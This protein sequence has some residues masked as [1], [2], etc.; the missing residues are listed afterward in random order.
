MQ[1]N[2]TLKTKLLNGVRLTRKPWVRAKKQKNEPKKP[3]EPS[4]DRSQD[5][6]ASSG[7]GADLKEMTSSVPAQQN[8]PSFMQNEPIYDINHLYEQI[9]KLNNPNYAGNHNLSW[10]KIKLQL[11]TRNLDEL[12]RK[13]SE[14]NVTLRQIGVDEERSFVD[15][16][17]LIGERLLQKDYQPFLVQYAKRGV[18]PTLRARIYKKILYTDVTQKET[19]YMATL[20]DNL[21]KWELALEDQIMTDL[22]VT[23]NDDKYF[24]FQEH[25]ESM[26]LTFFRDR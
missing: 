18:P 25:I 5:D 1:W 12:R 10:G 19:D 3:E 4:E 15:E 8:K 17:I 2:E 6:D 13:F 24:I 22:M 9:L 16:R 11:Y 21:N 26:V 23:C 7:S 20:T 14:L